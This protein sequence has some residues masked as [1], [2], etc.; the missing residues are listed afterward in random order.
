MA[1][2]LQDFPVPNLVSDF[3]RSVAEKAAETAQ[4][5]REITLDDVGTAWTRTTF[6]G[7][8]LSA[9]GSPGAFMPEPG[10]RMSQEMFDSVTEELPEASWDVF[11][12]ALN[13]EHALYLRNR[14][15]DRMDD[16]K[17]L[18]E[19]GWS[20]VGLQFAAAVADPLALLAD[21]ASF[22]TA[23]SF[24]VASKAPRL[25][26]ATRGALATG[27]SAG[28]INAAIEANDPLSTETDVLIAAGLGMT[29]GGG[30]GGAVGAVSPK[31]LGITRALDDLES[32]LGTQLTRTVEM[33]EAERAGLAVTPKGKK[34]AGI[35]GK[36][37][38]TEAF[39]DLQEHV[40]LAPGSVGAAGNP[41]KTEPLSAQASEEAKIAEGLNI[42]PGIRRGRIDMTG[43]L[44]SSKN[45][46]S[47][48]L[49]VLLAEDAVGL[50]DAPTPF[51]ASEEA[52]REWRSLNAEY[53]RSSNTNFR[54]W[55][56]D[57]NGATIGKGRLA[58]AGKENEFRRQVTQATRRLN[59]AAELAKYHPA[60]VDTARTMSRLQNDLLH[61]A[62]TSGMT[63]FDEIPDNV[64]YV[65]RLAN[66]DALEAAVKKYGTTQV[67]QLVA[68]AIARASDNLLPESA[69]KIAKQWIKTH[70]ELRLGAAN[71]R[72]TVR[73]VQDL[74]D[75][76]VDTLVHEKDISPER[77]LDEVNAMVEFR[78][79][80]GDG[81]MSRA[82]QRVQ[83]DELYGEDLLDIET[84]TPARFSMEDLFENDATTLFKLYSKQI[85]GHAAL[86][87]RGY[88]DAASLRAEIERVK[89]VSGE[90]GQSVKEMNEDVKILEI[91][92][93][94][95]TGQ[96]LHDYGL[97]HNR[98]MRRLMDIQFT[99]VMNQV[100]FAQIPEMGVLMGQVGI[101]TVLDQIPAFKGFVARSLKDGKIPN[102]TQQELEAIWG[103]GTDNLRAHFGSQIDDF[104][105]LDTVGRTGFDNMLDQGKYITSHI[106]GFNMVNQISH[107]WAN[108]AI[109][110]KF[111]QAAFK[112]SKISKKRLETLGLDQDMAERVYAQ[113]RDHSVTGEGFLTGRRMHQ[114]NLDAWKDR[115][116]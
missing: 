59:N 110:A 101:R 50:K 29:I 79:A 72:A 94:H 99:R 48:R 47:R 13:D 25:L 9:A 55:L 114:I 49:G 74:R 16:E 106:S 8:I 92:Q 18:A 11:E 71:A 73:G 61:R 15:L 27:V 88:P 39:P 30:I 78:Q 100:G 62:K 70:R 37:T 107:R 80:K 87:K 64:A 93:K 42:K 3:E 53:M 33:E 6:T 58:N 46:L 10:Y 111:A 22:G 24:A 52:M 54:A 113:I 116:A 56:K 77:A 44:V 76:M 38:L 4:D 89:K 82:K 109:V 115:E 85:T 96:P 41:F 97:T 2:V 20:G 51:G 7:Q 31:A 57:Y 43:K 40:D 17:K 66:R 68:N 19:L 103:F 45:P 84:Q 36:K 108:R 69:E 28:A 90:Y 63:G 83:M 105:E 12:G 60:V 98:L 81:E 23:R 65:T 26:A 112:K 5:A 34:Y 35:G 67:T 95:I 86:A 91:L 102:E 14:I 32:R 21:A 1:D 75:M 104:G